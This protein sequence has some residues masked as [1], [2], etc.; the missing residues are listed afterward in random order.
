MSQCG[1]LDAV[2]YRLACLHNP[3]H[4]VKLLTVSLKLLSLC[5]KLQVCLNTIRYLLSK[6]L[7]LFVN[8]ALY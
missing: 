5:V 4:T 1:G 8:Q 3:L 2:I 6:Y 7:F